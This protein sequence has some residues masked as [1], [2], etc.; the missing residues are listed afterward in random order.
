LITTAG[1]RKAIS[2][3]K[4][5]ATRAS[6]SARLGAGRAVRIWSTEDQCQAAATSGRRRNFRRIYGGGVDSAGQ[7]L[8]S[9]KILLGQTP[10]RRAK[11]RGIA[12]AAAKI[13]MQGRIA[14]KDFFQIERATSDQWD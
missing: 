9:E 4:F 8:N 7:T 10:R 14:P 2:P 3:A 11:K 6:E 5:F 12:A 13:N 1:K